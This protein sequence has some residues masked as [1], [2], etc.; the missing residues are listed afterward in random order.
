MPWMWQKNVFVNLTSH[1]LDVDKMYL[2]NNDPYEGK[3]KMLT[4]NQ[5]EG[6]SL[7]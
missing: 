2:Y 6:V 3:Q 1:Q 4:N 7:N 5:R